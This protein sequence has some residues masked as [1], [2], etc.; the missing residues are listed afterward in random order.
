MNIFYTTIRT[1]KILKTN[2]EF[3]SAK[4]KVNVTKQQNSNNSIIYIYLYT[5]HSI[6]KFVIVSSNNLKAV[7]DYR[8][9]IVVA[10]L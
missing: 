4:K 6:S 8:T 2:F 9:H 3:N 10:L 7:K 5:I 1:Y